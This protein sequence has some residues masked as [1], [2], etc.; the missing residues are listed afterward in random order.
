MSA[1]KPKVKELQDRVCHLKVVIVENVTSKNEEGSG[2]I[3]MT[4]PKGIERDIKDL[5]DILR[6]AVLKLLNLYYEASS[7]AN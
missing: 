2:E 6:C 3:I 4:R 1:V 7:T 5:E